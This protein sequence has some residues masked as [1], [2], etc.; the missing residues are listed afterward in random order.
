MILVAGDEIGRALCFWH[1][2]SS[3]LWI[4]RGPIRPMNVGFIVSS[5]A[6]MGRGGGR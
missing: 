2:L 1:S 4:P 6:S 5:S 3:K